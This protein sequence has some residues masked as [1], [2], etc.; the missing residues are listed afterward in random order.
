M[1]AIRRFISTVPP[2][3]LTFVLLVVVVNTLYLNYRRDSEVLWLLIGMYFITLLFSLGSIYILY[4]KPGDPA[5]RIFFIYLQLFAMASNAGAVGLNLNEPIARFLDMAFMAGTNIAVAALVHFHLVFPRPSLIY[6]KYKWLP[7][8][9]YC[10]GILFTIFQSILLSTLIDHPSDKITAIF[11]NAAKLSLIWLILAISVAI[12]LAVYQFFTIKN[13]LAR[14][15]VRIVIIGSLFGFITPILDGLFYAYIET[16]LVKSPWLLHMT[17]GPASL[18]MAACFT[19]AIFRYKIWGTE[20]FIRKALLYLSATFIII[21]TYLLLLILIDRLTSGETATTRFISLALSVLIFMVLRDNIQRLIERLFHRESYDSA[22]VVSDF[23]AK[24]SGIYHFDELSSGIGAGLDGIFHFKSFI[25][26]LKKKDNTYQPVY[27][28]GNNSEEIRNGLMAPL[29][30]ENKLRKAKVFSP[31]E[32]DRIPEYFEHAYGELIVPLLQDGQ[33]FGFFLCGPKKSEKSYSLQDIR[34]LSLLAQRTVALF[35]TAGLYQKDLD[36]QLMLERE[37]ARI[38]QD[39]HDDVGASLTRISMLSDL[40][41]NMADIREDARQWLGQI[42]DT[43]REV[44]EEMDQIIWAL[45]P[46]NDT[47]D[48]LASYIRRFAF[49]YLEPTTIECV[50]DFPDE[51]PDKALSVEVRRNIYLVF[52]E[53]LHNVIKHSGATRVDLKL[54][55]EDLSFKISIKDNGAGFEQE[56]L[57]FPGNG[58]VN[59]KKRMNDIGGEIVIGSKA[60]EGTE[61][62]LTCFT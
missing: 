42:S 60:G 61:I 46:K 51:I 48:G 39:M 2:W 29:G 53:A 16:L 59:M 56:K 7:W 18:I 20:I 30:F 45:N 35:Q 43:S 19:V 26:S 31:E 15:Q 17:H 55:V 33:P 34:V 3:A 58:L 50:F 25:F 22:T 1:N 47:L 38:S 57:E 32:I 23:E 40:V 14:N 13:T 11:Y 37:R 21:C 28:F 41:G 27:L 6:L 36:R 49:E 12:G 5:A 44:T 8:M 24:L 62:E 4:K 9:F 10:I 54:K 52:R